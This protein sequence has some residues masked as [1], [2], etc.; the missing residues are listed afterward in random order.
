V[1]V[2]GDIVK[3]NGHLVGAHVDAAR[4][5]MHETRERLRH[6]DETGSTSDTLHAIA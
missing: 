4:T 1:I 5:L 3:R 6:R 2:G